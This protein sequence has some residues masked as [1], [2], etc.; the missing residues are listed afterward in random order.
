[1][2]VRTHPDIGFRMER[3]GVHGRLEGGQATVRISDED[4]VVERESVSPLKRMLD[5]VVPMVDSAVASGAEQCHTQA[6]LFAFNIFGQGLSLFQAVQQLVASLLPVEAFAT[7]HGLVVVAARFEQMASS[8]S[9]RFGA[10]VRDALDTMSGFGADAEHVEARQSEVIAAAEAQNLTV[11]SQ[12]ADPE[13]SF[14]YRSLA[15]EM[16]FAKWA[17][18]GAYGAAG[19]HVRRVESRKAGFHTKLSPGPLSD[20]VGSAAVIAMLC[21]LGHASS[22]FDWTVDQDRMDRLLSEA[23]ELNESAAQLDLY[24]PD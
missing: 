23:R 21:L 9:P 4:I 13:S 20:L 7:L 19:L 5:S 17:A 11:P 24:P 6:S 3:I 18:N 16:N 8:G 2:T 22:L 14:I 1:M 10:A 12:L 15:V